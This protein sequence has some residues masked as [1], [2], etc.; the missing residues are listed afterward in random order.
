M[1]NVHIL[2]SQ[3]LDLYIKNTIKIVTA[4]P[5][6]IYQGET[7]EVRSELIGTSKPRLLKKKGIVL[8]SRIVSTP[9]SAT[10]ICHITFCLL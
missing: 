6:P 3:F 9:D 5:F 10:Y 4:S 1:K 2:P 8:W 7:I